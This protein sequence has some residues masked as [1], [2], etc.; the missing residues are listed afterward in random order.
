[1]LRRI[2]AALP[3][4]V[5]LLLWIAKQTF[6]FV[7]TFIRFQRSPEYA[8]SKAL[9]GPTLPLAKACAAVI[10]LNCLLLVF[11][12]CQITM[13]FLRQF[14]FLPFDKHRQLHR[15][16]SAAIVLFS[17]VHT[18]AHYINF[19]KIPTSWTHLAFLSGPGATG[20]VLWLLLLLV[21]LTAS[22]KAVRRSCFELYWY[23]H[24]LGFIF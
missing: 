15:L 11:S 18:I 19:A 16:A 14:K 9:L 3:E 5:G 10:N 21:V 13:T 12:M 6:L 1:M 8:S 4:A 24:Y 22:I 20:H 23:V 17:L 2:R 7:F